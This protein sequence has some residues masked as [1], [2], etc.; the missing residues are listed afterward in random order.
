MLVRVLLWNALTK[1]PLFSAAARPHSR[2]NAASSSVITLAHYLSWRSLLPSVSGLPCSSSPWPS[3]FTAFSGRG[4][5]LQCRQLWRQCW[6]ALNQCD[7]SLSHILPVEF[8]YR[9]ADFYCFQR[10]SL[11]FTLCKVK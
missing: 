10:C 1:F 6:G 5:H 11:H 2:G 8:L 9:R 7:D 3:S 4:E